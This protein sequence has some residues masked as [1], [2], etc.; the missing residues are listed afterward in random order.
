[1][2]ISFIRDT[3]RRCHLAN[4]PSSSQSSLIPNSRQNRSS[5]SLVLQPILL[6]M[7]TFLLNGPTVPPPSLISAELWPLN[8]SWR[9]STY[10]DAQPVAWTSICPVTVSYTHAY[11]PHP[12]LETQL[13]TE[14]LPPTSHSDSVTCLHTHIYTHSPAG[15]HMPS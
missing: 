7:V 6:W 12:L 13:H 5:P 2:P 1:M 9:P 11:H 14:A 10:I 15:E 4:A 3:E 8:F